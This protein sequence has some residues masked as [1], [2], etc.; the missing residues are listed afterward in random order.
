MSYIVVDASL[1][2][3]R[4]VP[5]D[6]FFEK[7]KTWMEDQR[8][9][10]TEFLSPALLLAEVAGAISRRTE[11]PEL[12]QRSLQ[13]LETLPNLRLV[14]MDE[15]LMRNAAELAAALG[16]RGADSTYVAV[17]DQLNLSLAT[18]DEDQRDR[19]SERVDVIRL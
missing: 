19:A 17:A 13:S 15:I 5:Q 8:R 2:V 12:G 9:A 10:G 7:V 16:L 4:L 1:W 18:L 6:H 14:A 3:A 11:S